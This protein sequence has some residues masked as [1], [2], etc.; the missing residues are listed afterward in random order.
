MCL[1]RWYRI[2]YLLYSLELNLLY[3]YNKHD[4]PKTQ[5]IQLITQS[6]KLRRFK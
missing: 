1:I 3:K 6:I 4:E 2:T 5:L